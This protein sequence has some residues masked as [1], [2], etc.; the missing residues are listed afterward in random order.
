MPCPPRYRRRLL[1]GPCHV[2]DFGQR[3]DGSGLSFSQSRL[4]A[5]Q[6]GPHVTELCAIVRH[7]PP[8]GPS[9]RMCPGYMLRTRDA[10]PVPW[11][12]LFGTPGGQKKCRLTGGGACTSVGLGGRRPMPSIL[13][14][15]DVG[16][17][18]ADVVQ[19]GSIEAIDARRQQRRLRYFPRIA[20]RNAAILATAATGR[21]TSTFTSPA[22]TS[23]EWPS[24]ESI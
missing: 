14:K 18:T 6:S 19:R 11:P 4:C 1:Q 22:S 2:L 13:A 7:R 8:N 17:L 16:M 24:S 23:P 9:G 5:R 3:E 20:F 12:A 10:M 15:N 21:S